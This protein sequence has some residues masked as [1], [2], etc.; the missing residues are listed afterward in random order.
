MKKIQISS[1]KSYTEKGIFCNKT[2]FG[3]K[4]EGKKMICS[5]ENMI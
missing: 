1:R 3:R 5:R 4:V 2:K